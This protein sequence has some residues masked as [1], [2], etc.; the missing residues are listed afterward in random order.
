MLLL[1]YGILLKFIT[2][3]KAVILLATLLLTG[4]VSNGQ[5]K[6]PFVYQDSNTRLQFGGFVRTVAF[7]D[8]G[9]IVPHYDFRNA[10]MSVPGQ[11][12]N[13][14]RL[15]LDASGTRLSF[16]AVQKTE[17]L[18]DIEF[19][20]ESDFRG[21]GDALR[22]RQAYVSFKGIIAGQTWSFMT[23][24]PANATTIDVQGVNSRT[25]LRT[26]LIGY[27]GVIDQ[28]LSYGI[29]LEFPS[30]RYT[31]TAD[32][33]AVN[34]RLPDLP[35]YVQ[36]KGERGHLKLAGMLRVLDY[37]VNSSEEIESK[38]G[39]GA[40]L[41]GSL[42][43]AAGLTLYSQA[44]LGKGISRYIND[45]ALVSVDLVPDQAND[46]L[47][48][49]PMYGISLGAKSDFAKDLYATAN[50]SVAGL[51]NKEDYFSANEYYTGSYFSASLFW[52]AARNMTIAGEFIHGTRKNMG[53]EK[54]S[55][56][57][58]QVMFMYKW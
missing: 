42:K 52:N 54:G 41:S 58:L 46:G 35:F 26:P 32:Y 49:L 50:I 51:M 43:A 3:R 29:A 48:T 56:N 5:G 25:F 39:F 11:W 34:Q 23:D 21:S 38:A 19:Y 14:S 28:N 1:L 47:Q 20:I 37:G 36:Y 7:A 31:V 22:L 10:L 15:S 4:F 9:G 33:R 53:D 30:V 55:A 16:K 6:S 24:L 17:K 27:R 12:H 2:M 40:Q 18:G 13:D 45:L 8:F 44:I 57:R